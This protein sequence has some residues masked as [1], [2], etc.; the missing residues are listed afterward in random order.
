MSFRLFIYYCAL[1]GGWAALF[2]W[3]LGLSFSPTS[4]TIRDGLRGM[5]LGILVAL[6]LSLVDCL[7]N[8]SLRQIGQIL[9]RVGVALLVGGVG[10][11]CGGFIG[12]TLYQAS[13]AFFVFG[14]A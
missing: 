6:G 9:M 14:W 2:G 8:L 1:C 12:S 4:V 11:L 3:L 5:M 7:W 10:G 13:A